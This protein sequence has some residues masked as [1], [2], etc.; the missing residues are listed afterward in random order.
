MKT[1]LLAMALSAACLR[2]DVEF[3]GFFITPFVIP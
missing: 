3:S 2:A 1:L